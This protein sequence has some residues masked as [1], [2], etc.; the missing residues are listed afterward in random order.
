M[1]SSTLLLLL[2]LLMSSLSK[3]QSDTIKFIIDTTNIW[4]TDRAVPKAVIQST[5]SY[6]ERLL[7]DPYR[8]AYHFCLTEGNGYPGDPNGAFYHNGRYHLMYLYNR[9]GSGFSWGHVSSKDMLHWR[10]H[11]DALMPSDGDE[12]AFSGGAFVDDDGTSYLS[13]WMLWGAKGIGLTKSVDKDFNEYKKLDA[14]PVIKSTEWGIT[15]MTDKSGKEIHV[16]SADPSNIW[17][18]D[19]KYYMLTGNLLVLRKYGSRGKGLIA[20]RDD[21]EL[22]KDSVNYQGD[23]L[24]LFVSDDL[25][26]WDYVHR[27]YESK[28]KWTSKTE[29][30]MCP[31]FLPLPMSEN[32]GKTSDKHL[33]L[34]IS[35]N[36]GCQ[37]YIGD[38]K[39]DKFFPQNHGRMTW[40]DKAYFAPEAL[41][42]DKGR[43]IMWTWIFDDRP[44]S[45]KNDIGWTGTYGLP[46]SLW[47]GEDGTL[48]MNPVK[49]LEQLRLNEQSQSDVVVKSGSDVSLNQLSH[50]LM[51]LEITIAPNEADQFGVKVSVS[52][53]GE[54]ETVIY[55][56]RKD[57]KLKLDT[58]RSGL[59]FGRKIIEEAPF[60]LKKN[61]PLVLKIYMDRSIV[62]VYANERQAIARRIYPTLGGT[63]VSAFSKGGKVVFK[64]VKSWEMMPSNPY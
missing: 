22:S 12:G 30:N 51:E 54:E 59:T 40:Q 3:G 45:V 1:K 60:D 55:Y 64:S 53:N 37:Y 34:F 10:H 39:Q 44:D 58:R 35:H 49:E 50:E 13:Y 57:K 27:F 29:D 14:N 43:Q 24:D 36:L 8:P 19:G 33:L 32:G 63:G 20:N 2:T 26:K 62:E 18:K 46:R 4:I 61:E 38:Y 17:K 23:W 47:L 11:P 42:D 16:G 5:R 6:R 7:A 56:D 28:R 25:E 52:E 41:V 21:L 9:A 15:D 31:S 48:R